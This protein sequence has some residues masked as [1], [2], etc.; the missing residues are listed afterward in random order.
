MSEEKS[1]E[2]KIEMEN[3]HVVLRDGTSIDMPIPKGSLAI[4]GAVARN[5][6]MIRNENVV[7]P[8]DLIKI[9]VRQPLA[10]PTVLPVS[11]ITPPNPGWSWGQ[12][13]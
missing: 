6:G 13:N 5:D 11:G 1:D 8:W 4:L 2:P 7:I 12:P 3:I 10:Q 9:I